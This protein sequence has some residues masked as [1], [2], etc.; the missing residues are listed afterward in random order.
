MKEYIYNATSPETAIEVDNYPWGFRM[1]T[2]QRYW[3]ESSDKHGQRFVSQTMNPKNGTWC[4]PKKGTYCKV[5]VPYRDA[6]TGHI[7][8][9]GINGYHDRNQLLEFYERHKDHLTDFQKGKLREMHAIKE[10]F[11]KVTWTVREGKRTPEEEEQQKR[12]KH[13]INKAIEFRIRTDK[14]FA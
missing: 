2:K 4:A 10:V 1:K 5:I 3:V 9:E 8:H 12:I 14:K 11:E 7:E 6:E 13:D